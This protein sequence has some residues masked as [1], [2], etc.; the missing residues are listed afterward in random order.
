LAAGACALGVAALIGASPA[1]ADTG[2]PSGCPS[3]TN[4]QTSNLVGASYS[5]SANT[6]TYKFTSFGDQGPVDGVPGLIAYCVYPGGTAPDSTTIDAVGDNGAAWDEP[7]DAGRFSF[8]RPDGNPSNIGLDGRTDYQM[9]T[10]TWSGGA[11]ATQTIL[12]H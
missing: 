2:G 7:P 12:L 6:T 9:G 3:T 10:A 11:P 5:T 1:P 8:N 4:K